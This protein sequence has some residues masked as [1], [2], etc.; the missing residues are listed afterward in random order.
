MRIV[1]CALETECNIM[2]EYTLY[3]WFLGKKNGKLY[4]IFDPQIDAEE[5]AKRDGGK[6][7][8]IQ[9][10]KIQDFINKVS[11]DMIFIGAFK[12]RFTPIQCTKEHLRALGHEN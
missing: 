12:Q 2:H 11:P 8:L 3:Y 4:W 9:G 6:S 10:D 7:T 1:A 5:I